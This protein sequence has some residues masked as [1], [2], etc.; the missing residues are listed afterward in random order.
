M[1]ADVADDFA[2]IGPVA[3]VD[4]DLIGWCPDEPVWRD[5]ERFFIEKE[6]S[7]GQ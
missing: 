7:D 1:D 2:E 6:V 5:V 3:L 4:A